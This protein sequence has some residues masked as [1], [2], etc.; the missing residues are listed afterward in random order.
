MEGID[1]EDLSTAKLQSIADRF[2]A[3]LLESV[4][5]ADQS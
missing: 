3:R 2:V 1:D 4:R 5:L